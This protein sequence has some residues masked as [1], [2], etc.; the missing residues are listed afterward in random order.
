MSRLLNK[1]L[2]TPAEF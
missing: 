2:E 1:L